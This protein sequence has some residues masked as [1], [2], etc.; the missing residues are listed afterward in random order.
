MINVEPRHGVAHDM[1]NMLQNNLLPAK[2]ALNQKITLQGAKYLDYEKVHQVFVSFYRGS[3]NHF[4]LL[5][6]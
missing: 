2:Y 1:V 4:I 5:I 3:I 6:S